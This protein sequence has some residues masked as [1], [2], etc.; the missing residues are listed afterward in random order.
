MSDPRP[1]THN[2][3]PVSAALSSAPLDDQPEAADEKAALAEARCWLRKNG[4]KGIPHAEAMRRL[5]LE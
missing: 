5:G 2:D 1:H 3:D 4:G